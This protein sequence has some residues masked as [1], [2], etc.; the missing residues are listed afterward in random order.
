MNSKSLFQNHFQNLP[1]STAKAHG[2]VNLIGEHTDY[3]QG[4]VLPTLIE[5]YIEVSVSLRQ[6]SKILGVSEEFGEVEVDLNSKV[7]GSW[8]DFIRGACYYIE[9]K[10]YPIQGLNIAVTSSVPTGSGLSSSAALEISLLR[11]LTQLHGI[12]ISSQEIAKIGQSIEHNFIGIQC[13]IMDQMASSTAKFGQALFLDCENLHSEIIPVF[14]DHTFVVIH[15]G[16]TRKLSQGKYNERKDETEMA[17]NILKI[18]SLRYATL[19]QLELIEDEIIRKRA[20]HIITENERVINATAL[21]KK[22]DAFNFGQ[23]MNQSH[24]SMDE[25]Y[26]IS[27]PELNL[28]V[29]AAKEAGSLGARLTGAGFGGCVVLLTTNDKAEDMQKIVL[30]NCPNSYWVTNISQN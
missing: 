22:G 25:D 13:G 28:V 11:A 20:R 1:L 29:K 10:N 5:Q 2:R 12:D 24:A 30:R 23:L 18:P 8:I 26:E 19:D 16:S 17:S 14:K 4:F 15:S 21:L 27:S 7:D 3:N 9:Q 6:D